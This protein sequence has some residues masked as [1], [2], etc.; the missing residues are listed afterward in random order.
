M[1]DDKKGLYLDQQDFFAQFLFDINFDDDAD[2]SHFD[3][4]LSITRL[5]SRFKEPEQARHLLRAL[6]VLNN[7]RYFRD[8]IVYENTGGTVNKQY[9]IGK[10]PVCGVE[11]VSSD[12][13]VVHCDREFELPEIITRE[14]PEV[15]KVIKKKSLF[16]RTYHA[17]KSRFLS[18]VTTSMARDGHLMKAATTTH[19]N[20]QESVE[21]RTNV[22]RNPFGFA[23]SRKENEGGY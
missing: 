5:A 7:N 10:C 8:V 15:Q 21:D 22:K 23:K 9:W 3:K 16:P 4:N 19:W 6:H 11:L 12:Q 1:D 17:L 13:N 2:F 14:E 20:K 18:L